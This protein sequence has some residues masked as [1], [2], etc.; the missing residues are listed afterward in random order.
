MI[1]AMPA[2]TFQP[3]AP[4]QIPGAMPYYPAPGY[5][6]PSPGSPARFATSPGGSPAR[7]ATGAPAQARMG[8]AQPQASPA[9]P[10][11]PASAASAASAPV[12]DDGTAAVFLQKY[13]Q[14]VKAHCD[15]TLMNKPEAVRELNGK[16]FPIIVDAFK[17]HDKDGDGVLQRTEASIFFSLFTSDRLGFSDAARG[18]VA[19]HTGDSEKAAEQM[20]AYQKH[21]EVLDRKAF[22]AFNSH[23]DGYLQLHEVISG[24]SIGSE[25][26]DAILKAFGL[27]PG[28]NEQD[29]HYYTDH[30]A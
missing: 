1:A 9:S 24:L 23:E 26:N 15:H 14:L 21:K 7:F 2:Q 4:M 17:R 5:Q 30:Y 13:F 3:Y 28:D 29:D 19:Q 12:L 10:A 22:H 18:M 27:R 11:S 25:K 16:L 6:M 8:A 20:A